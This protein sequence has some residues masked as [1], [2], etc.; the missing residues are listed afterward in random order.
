MRTTS[1]HIKKCL[2][3]SGGLYADC[4]QPYHAQ[5]ASAPTAE[6]L[7]RSRYVAYVLG[8][9]P[10]LLA[11]W[12]TSTRPVSLDLDEEPRPN[13]LGLEIKRHEL[14]DD[15]HALVE[16]VARYKIGGRAY[17][18]HETSRFVRED[19]QWFYIDGVFAK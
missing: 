6:A 5:I 10:Y 8:L 3:G 19:N 7:M 16:F 11:T 14:E 1:A 13:W 18:L 9:E 17:R 2:C 4:C 12:H 15:N